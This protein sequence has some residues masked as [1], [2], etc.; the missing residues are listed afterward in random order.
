MKAVILAAGVGSRLR[1][2]TNRLPKALV[3]VAGRP[4]IG[5]Q[6]DALLNHGIEDII[7]CTGYRHEAVIDYCSTSFPQAHIE[8]VINKI[9][10][11]TNNMYSLYLAKDH[12]KDGFILMNGDVVFDHSIIGGMID[13]DGSVVACD[14]GR[15]IDESMKLRIDGDVIVD[16]SKELDETVAHGCS[17]D[18]YKFIADDAL[19]IRDQLID[20]IERERDLNQWTEVL[21]QRLFAGGL[22]KARPFDID[23]KCWTEI[24]DFDDL[25]DAEKLFNT[26]LQDISSKGIFFIDRDGTVTLGDGPID[27]AV[28]LLGKLNDRNIPFYILTN[29]SSRTRKQHT[30][31]FLSHGLP[32]DEDNVLVST[33][34]LIAFLRE[35][36]ITRLFLVANSLVSEYFTEQGFELDDA[37]PE[38]LVLTFDDQ[39]DY[40][41]ITQLTRLVNRGIPY[42]GTHIDL[43]YPSEDGLLPDI[44]TYINMIRDATGKEPDAT[45]GKP[46]VNMIEP[47]MRKHDLTPDDIVIV[48][49]RLYTDIQLGKNAGATTVLV[50]S[51]ET[52]RDDPDLDEI[53]PDIILN[54]VKDLAELL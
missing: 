46:S 7:I 18:V 42:Y 37:D 29:N 19:T 26:S 54:S 13:M 52:R 20:I 21:L 28:D 25:N 9:F 22:L 33:D 12:I 39:I 16:I 30:E 47:I 35:I 48:G 49:D 8:Y 15:Y 24:D 6:I 11:S 17:I 40:S 4:I 5:H 2:L 44:G 27:G 43:L 10:E 3:E 1:P 36:G 32:L 51:G 38:A 53:R 45:F 14:V 34:S 50:L 41:K 31:R 23:G